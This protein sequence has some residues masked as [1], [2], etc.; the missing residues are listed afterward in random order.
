MKNVLSVS[1]AAGLAAT[2]LLACSGSSGDSSSD[3]QSTNPTSCPEAG[4][5]PSALC[6]AKGG[7]EWID[8][9]EGGYKY[10]VLFPAPQVYGKGKVA[11]T[12]FVAFDKVQCKGAMD[13]QGTGTFRPW[14]EEDGMDHG[15]GEKYA[16]RVRTVRDEE[17]PNM[18]AVTD[19]HYLMPGKWAYFVEPKFERG[20]S[21]IGKVNGTVVK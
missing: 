5:E 2:L 4:S 6:L 16:P 1:L 20:K 13:A 17:C 7:G 9:S 11:N 3:D 14:M 10:K 19:I 12:A 15:L 8:S 18:F 21:D